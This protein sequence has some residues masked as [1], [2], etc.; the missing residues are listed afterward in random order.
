MGI[1]ILLLLSLLTVSNADVWAIGQDGPVVVTRILGRDVRA[2][3]HQHG[4]SRS[5]WD[6]ADVDT[7]FMGY[8]IKA[9]VERKA[10]ELRGVVHVYPPFGKKLTYHFTGKINGKSIVASHHGG[11]GFH[12]RITG[13][14]TV[15]GT[16]TDKNG[17]SVPV[18]VALPQMGH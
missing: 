11:H 18:K 16:F 13:K 8:K 6:T 3:V 7:G 9:T 17:M 2:V 5:G 1:R 12:G 4:R 15:E 10:K 14:T